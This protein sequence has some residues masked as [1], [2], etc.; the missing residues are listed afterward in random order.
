MMLEHYELLR[1]VRRLWIVGHALS[2]VGC[3]PE[4][5]HRCENVGLHTL[6]EG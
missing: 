1:L 6:Q 5:L 3:V 2:A 4:F